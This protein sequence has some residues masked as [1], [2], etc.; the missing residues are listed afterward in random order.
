M[1]PYSVKLRHPKTKLKVQ[2]WWVGAT[3][4]GPIEHRK[5]PRVVL[6]HKRH[7][8]LVRPQLVPWGVFFLFLFGALGGFEKTSASKQL[9]KQVSK[10][11]KEH[12]HRLQEDSHSYTTMQCTSH[13][14]PVA[15][16]VLPQLLLDHY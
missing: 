12:T 2:A 8:L 16:G 11:A 4:D 7:D 1:D 13:V 6:L 10:L 5:E 14:L 3:D 15:V 9:S